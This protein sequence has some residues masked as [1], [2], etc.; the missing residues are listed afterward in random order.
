MPVSL[1]I[2]LAFVASV[3]NALTGR[4][5]VYF[6]SVTMFVFFLGLGRYVEMIARHR[7]GSVADALARLAPMTARRVRDGVAEDVQAIEL[8]VGDELRGAQPAR[9]SRP[10]ASCSRATGPR[11]RVDAHRANRPRSPKPPGAR[12]H[13]GTHNLA[14]PLRVRV[15]AVAGNTVL[16]GHRRAA[17][18][19]AGRAAAAREGRRPRRRVVPRAA[20]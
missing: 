10:T 9:C 19:R 14:A 2:V 8:A 6:D 4:G 15:A 5:E 13:Q 16:V 3:W 20:S 18:A 7:A 11:R 17:R 12:V 1:G